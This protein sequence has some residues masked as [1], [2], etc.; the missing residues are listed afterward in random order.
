MKE[1]KK[2][3]I[4]FNKVLKTLDGKEMKKTEDG[5]P[6]TQ[7][8]VVVSA[9]LQPLAEVSPEE[10]WERYKVGKKYFNATEPLEVTE[11]EKNSIIQEV[12]KRHTVT[13]VGASMEAMEE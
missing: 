13:L 6:L 8:D 10:K 5:S 3:K 11:T 2:L 9:Y 4:D 7:K 12:C 1:T